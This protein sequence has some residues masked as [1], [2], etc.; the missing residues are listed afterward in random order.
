MSADQNYDRWTMM[1]LVGAEHWRETASSTVGKS[2]SMD[3]HDRKP[4]APLSKSQKSMAHPNAHE[5]WEPKKS[6]L[7]FAKEWSIVVW[8]EEK[9]CIRRDEQLNELNGGLQGSS[10][11]KPKRCDA[12]H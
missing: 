10:L 8:G 12:G 4:A 2:E 1:A 7:L 3:W 11:R 9:K 6:R 5:R